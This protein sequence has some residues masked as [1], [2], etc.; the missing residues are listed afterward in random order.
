MNL[1]RLRDQ[2]NQSLAERFIL[3]KQEEKLTK[4]I[5]ETKK[6]LE[7]AKSAQALIQQ[8]AQSVQ[9]IAHAGIAGIV[10][11]CL[12]TVFGEDF[13]SEFVIRFEQKRGRT[14]ARLVLVDSGG[15]ELNPLEADAGGV[16]DVISFGLRIA[17][18]LL[19][20]PARRK[21][22]VLDEPFKMLSQEY[23]P[24]LRRMLKVISQE[25]EVQMIMVTHSPELVCGEVVELG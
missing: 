12:R 10:T 18:L 14:E 1:Q 22:L 7:N 15:E 13:P 19:T 11:R 6:E 17:C 8:V 23:R 4:E 16:V 3:T 2:L 25:F 20:S 5:Q 24:T 9:E 21:L